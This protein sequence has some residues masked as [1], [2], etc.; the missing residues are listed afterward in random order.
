M[1]KI[2]AAVGTIIG[3]I[4]LA[5]FTIF[6]VMSPPASGVDLPADSLTANIALN[7]PGGAPALTPPPVT[8]DLAATT[9]APASTPAEEPSTTPSPVPTPAL[10]PAPSPTATPTP[11][12]TPAPTPAEPAIFSPVVLTE[13]SDTPPLATTTITVSATPPPPP[14]SSEPAAP[15]GTGAN[16]ALPYRES[17]FAGDAN[18]QT[19]WGAET[20]TNEGSLQLAAGANSIGGAVYLK[21]DPLWTNYAMNA[22]VDLAGGQTFGL[23]ADYHDASNY[24]LCEYTASP[25]TVNVQFDQFT[26]GYKTALTP[27]V[28]IPWGNASGTAEDSTSPDL[29]VAIAVHGVYGSCSLNGQLVSNEGAGPGKVPMSQSGSGTIGFT[30]SDPTPG[31]SRLTVKSVSVAAD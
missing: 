18:W 12:P 31:T 25:G 6:F 27:R 9:S 2:V 5:S 24:I 19:T 20:V 7:A 26:D 4:A 17:N 13:N 10:N 16:L 29:N 1:R 22:V 15:Q 23:M 30:V 8:P 14:P 21:N 11:V 3:F 28:A